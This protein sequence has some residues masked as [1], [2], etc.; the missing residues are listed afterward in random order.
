MEISGGVA[1]VAKGFR[2]S[3]R[4]GLGGRVKAPLVLN[5]S[6]KTVLLETIDT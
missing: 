6:P 4:Q 1:V 2:G 3:T 5:R